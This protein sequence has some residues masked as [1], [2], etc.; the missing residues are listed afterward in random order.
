MNKN[1]AYDVTAT[2]LENAMLQLGG[3]ASNNVN[4]GVYKI[5]DVT[6]MTKAGQWNVQTPTYDREN[7]ITTIA[8]QPNIISPVIR[9]GRMILNGNFAGMYDFVYHNGD[10]DL[11]QQT[12]MGGSHLE[13]LLFS[14]N[15]DTHWAL[16]YI[17][18]DLTVDAAVQIK[19]GCRKLGMCIYVAGD[20]KVDGLV[21]MTNRGANHSGKGTSGGYTVPVAIP[22]NGTLTIPAA[23]GVGGARAGPTVGITS[24]GAWIYNNGTAAGGS[25]TGTYCGSGGGAS[26]MAMHYDATVNGGVYSGKGGNGT[27]FSGGSG[28]A[29]IMEYNA[30]GAIQGAA[31]FDEFDAI[32]YGGAGGH[33]C[34]RYTWPYMSFG[35]A[36]NPA[37]FMQNY[38]DGN[39]A[40]VTSRFK[41]SG[42]NIFVFPLDVQEEWNW[43]NTSAFTSDN[44]PS[45]Q[46]AQ[47]RGPN[48]YNGGMEGTGGTL[49]MMITGQYSG[50]GAVRATG[51][52]MYQ[53]A[54]FNASIGAGGASGGGIG[55]VLYGTDSSGPTPV[56]AGGVGGNAYAGGAGGAGTGLKASL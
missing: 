48:N 46:Y 29:G 27:C 37:G 40:T 35:G 5:N 55:I 25:N 21:S 11:S 26:G 51:H 47:S 19:P 18:G 3:S 43:W 23:G 36:G 50:A 17:N 49:V 53:Y 20:C 7:Q 38:W 9:S 30:N 12:Q 4:S 56:A 31:N 2:T 28:G 41:E 16:I 10:L 39:E 33:A 6:S 34:A 32:E 45:P 22:L 24:N 14:G 42:E 13:N 52:A 54:D 15:Q 1:L 44:I 8:N